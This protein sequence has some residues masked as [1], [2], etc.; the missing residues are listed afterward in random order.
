MFYLQEVV[1]RDRISRSQD[2]HLVV[3]EELTIYHLTVICANLAD[4][5]AAAAAEISWI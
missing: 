1:I 4:L 2:K 3:A 5:A